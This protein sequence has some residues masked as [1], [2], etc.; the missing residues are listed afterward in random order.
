MTKLQQNEAHCAGIEPGEHKRSGLFMNKRVFAAALCLLM[1]LG[2]AVG[3]VPNVA[4]A[5]PK[6]NFND[7]GKI[8]EFLTQNGNGSK[9]NKSFNKTDPSTYGGITTVKVGNEYRVKTIN[10][11]NKGLKGALDLSGFAYLQ[12][13]NCA[14]NGITSLKFKG[15]KRLTK[16]ICNNNSISQISGLKS[17]SKLKAYASSASGAFATDLRG[18]KLSSSYYTSSKLPSSLSKNSKWIKAQ[19]GEKGSKVK[20]SSVS[21]NVKK[22]TLAV[23]ESYTLKATIKPSSMSD[24]KLT[25]SSS[26]KKVATV[27]SKGIVTAK[28]AGTTT[29]T[30]KSSNGK[31]ATCKITVKGNANKSGV[32]LDKSEATI[33]KDKKLTLKAT[34][35]G[36]GKIS[37]WK[38]SDTTVATVSKSGVVTAK[39]AGTAT[40]TVKTKGGSTAKAVIKVVN[41]QFVRE[42]P[43]KGNRGTV[44]ISAKKLRYRG[45]YLEMEV[46]V[47]NNSET[48]IRKLA[49]VNLQLKMAD[50]TK[51]T[52]KTIKELDLGKTVNDKKYTIKTYKV[53]ASEVGKNLNL[54]ECDVI[55]VVS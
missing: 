32:K 26:N 22:K 29:I 51:K 55:G 16:L 10:W 38:S 2:I 30:A 8:R 23:D 52:V 49:D 21:L 37:S 11:N 24:S 39:K 48:A 3:N 15:N 1:V 4:Y 27:S 25:W 33:V 40:I 41:N 5:K 36:G 12:S 31:K 44:R 14:N 35:T 50:G 43:V 17:L 28:K 45:N 7:F 34:V 54:T 6:Y 9:L 18:N 42:S 20:V 13:V 19:K 53:K 46:F 47:F